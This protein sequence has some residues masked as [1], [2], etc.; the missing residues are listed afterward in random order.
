MLT[1]LSLPNKVEFISKVLSSIID[2]EAVKDHYHTKMS[3][4]N[5]LTLAVIATVD[6]DSNYSKTID[7]FID[8]KI[9]NFVLEKSQ[10][11]R[12]IKRIKE[13]INKI[14]EI[15]S[16]LSLDLIDKF[17]LLT[18]YSKTYIT[19]TFPIPIVKQNR[20]TSCRMVKNHLSKEKIIS[21][22]TNRLRKVIDEDYRGFCA[23]KNMW[24]YGF[25]LSPIVNCF[26]LVHNYSICPART[27]DPNCLLATNINLPSNSILLADSIY[28]SEAVIESLNIGLNIKL[29]PVQKKS[30]KLRPTNDNADYQ[31]R[32]FIKYARR[33]VETNLS[34]IDSFIPKHFKAVCLDTVI[35]KINLSILSYNFNKLYEIFMKV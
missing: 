18:N 33:Q 4:I 12:R 28:D 27:Y 24:Y 35:L 11:S 7:I 8:S 14:V 31:D 29:T 32:V 26:G 5:L 21:P 3:T 13:L 9:F 30:K 1:H 20:I 34:Q 6:Y 2:R 25:K 16:Q 19:D 15:I 22:K 10:F 23:S 17:I